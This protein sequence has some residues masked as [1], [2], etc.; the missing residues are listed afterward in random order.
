MNPFDMA[1]CN[2]PEFVRCY[3][4]VMNGQTKRAEKIGPSLFCMKPIT[5]HH[6]PNNAKSLKFFPVGKSQ[7]LEDAS[8]G[9]TVHA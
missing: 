7:G 5:P 1:E 9:S 3:N 4:H 2:N 8:V 6:N